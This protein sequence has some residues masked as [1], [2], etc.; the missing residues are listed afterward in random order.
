MMS[1]DTRLRVEKE[2]NARLWEKEVFDFCFTFCYL[3]DTGAGIRYLC[4]GPSD[5]RIEL[6]FDGICTVF[7]AIALGAGTS[8]HAAN[9][10]PRES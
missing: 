10:R 8:E 9:Q 2:R 3:S 1:L 4:M 5:E 7:T 6:L